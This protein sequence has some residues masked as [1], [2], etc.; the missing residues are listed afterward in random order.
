MAV[1]VLW[2]KRD[3]RI[4]DHP[5]L[6]VAARQDTPVLPIYIIEPELWSQPD[7]SARQWRFVFES[8]QDLAQDMAWLGAPMHV[9]QG[10]AV[11]VLETIHRRHRIE[12]LVSHQETG[13]L[14]SYA[15]DRKVGAWAVANGIVWDQPPQSGVIRRLPARDGWAKARDG[16]M[17]A[18]KVPA[19]QQLR[20]VPAPEFSLPDARDLGLGPDGADPQRGGARAAEAL[21]DSF[22]SE[23]GRTYRSAMSS[24]LAGEDVCSRLSPHFAWG[25]LTVR[26][27]VH[28]TAARQREVRNTREGWIGSLKS[29]QARLAWRDHFTQKLEDEPELEIRAMHSAYESLRPIVPDAALLSAW[30]A[31]ETGVPFVDACMR[32]LTATG[33]LNFRMRSMLVAFASYH[34]WL[35]W[36]ATGPVLARR[37]TDYEPGIHWPQMQ[38]QSGVTGMNTIRIYNPIKQGA[39]QDP[40]GTFTRRWVPELASVPAQFLQ[41]PWR[42][43]QFAK[44]HYPQ[45]IVDVPSAART[46][47]EKVWSV[48]RGR[49][50]GDEAARVV[51]KHASRKGPHFVND[52]A[53]RRRKRDDPRQ[54]N[55][56][57]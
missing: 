21:L 46:A 14:W 7:A 22:L 20:G 52:R 6:A 30:T 38:M 48:R 43:D 39:D 18:D 40:D 24:P 37:F 1:T 16:Y 2:F 55:L 45:P 28:A 26:T 35:D 56:D 27:A 57:V 50:F 15:R 41:Q 5:A 9:V 33:W 36:R 54:L 19:P 51:K 13:N 49:A 42:W 12:R 25:T 11:E 44:L 53:P 23:R 10:E 4:R 17:F 29:F 32:Y 31:G 47:R 3:L 8:L 34:L